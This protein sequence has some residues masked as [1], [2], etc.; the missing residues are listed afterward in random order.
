METIGRENLRDSPWQLI[1]WYVLVFRV[2]K[3]DR[4]GIFRL[5]D[6]IDIAFLVNIFIVLSKGT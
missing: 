6:W 1:I 3:K 2:H 4:L 5:Q